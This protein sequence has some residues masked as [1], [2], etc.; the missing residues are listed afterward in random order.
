[1][2]SE[3][4]PLHQLSAW[5]FAAMVPVVIQL[6]AG[7]SWVVVLVV[8][9]VGLLAFWL[10]KRWGAVPDGKIYPALIWIT[11]VLLIG[12]LSE[13]TI[14]CWPEGGHVAVPLILLGLA[15]WSAWKGTKAV[16]G[17]GSVLFWFLLVLFLL[18]FGAGVREIKAGWL[19][20]E[21]SDIS[22]MGCILLL[23]PLIALIHLNKKD[24]NK[25]S[26]VAVTSVFCVVA[27]IITA[28]VLS[29]AVA[30]GKVNPFYEM[31][32]SLTILG[33]ARRFEA[34]LSAGTTVGWFALFSLY[35]SV[36]GEMSERFAQGW[37]RKGILLAALT[38][39]ALVLWNVKIPGWILLILSVILWLVVPL[40]AG[41]N[42]LRKKK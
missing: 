38:A 35:L 15:L 36:C 27:T 32:R 6:T 30:S 4:I 28:G 16:A 5:L 18:L 1:M 33:Q 23:S 26:S 21:R 14:R 41:L 24:T 22:P 2:Y 19:L 25:I 17:V 29:P 11:M 10:R 20:P 37:G 39:S 40:I 12:T 31:T 8:A 42:S 3:K 34:I 9:T 7:A 13:E